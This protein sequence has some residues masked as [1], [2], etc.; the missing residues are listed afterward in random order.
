M[1]QN[2]KKYSKDKTKLH[3]RNKHGQRY[4]FD[5]LINV[6][7]E[8]ESFVILNKY[9][10]KSVDFSN[11]EAVK[12][13]NRALLKEYYSIEHW[14][15]PAPYLYPPIPGRADYIHHIADLLG[16][17]NYGK[18]PTGP[19]IKCLDIGVGANCIYPIIGNTEYGWSFVG[20]DIDPQ[21]LDSAKGIINANPVLEGKIELKLQEN[22]S[23]FFYGV[24]QKDE[25]IDLSICNPPLYSSMEEVMADSARKKSNLKK[26]KAEESG[27]N[28]EGQSHELW[29][30]GG[31]K[32]FITKMIRESKK[33]SSSCFWFS[34][35]VSKQSNLKHA[36]DAL[37]KAEAV[38]IKTIAM[39]QGMGI[40]R[41]VAWTFLTSEQQK[42]WAKQRWNV[43]T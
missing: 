23:D 15:V 32:R 38:E 22:P 4:D 43:S 18:M 27:G 19:N 20:S 1:S 2:K 9:Q 14:D 39:G 6:V 10:E 30:E 25:Q 42:D 40:N 35:L 29:C 31:E 33:F 5:R 36:Y 21:A 3:T 26:E 7:P 16:S 24:I 17:R 13:L 34:T 41:I 11:P 8:L 12:M 28:S 37:A